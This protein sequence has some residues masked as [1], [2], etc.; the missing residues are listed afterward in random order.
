V[1]I[2]SLLLELKEKVFF[3]SREIHDLFQTEPVIGNYALCYAM[4]FAK[5]PYHIKEVKK[6]SPTYKEDIS[7][8]NVKGIYITPATPVQ[9]PEME[10]ERFNAMV[11]S[12]WYTMSNNAV[13]ADLDVKLK[14]KRASTTCFPQSGRIR[15]LSRGSMFKCFLCSKEEIKIPPYIRVGKFMGKVKV[16]IEKVF[17]NLKSEEKSKYII[18]FYLNPLD[19]GKEVEIKAYDLMSIHPVPLI[20]NIESSGKFFK[21]DD[22]YLPAG[23]E[24]SFP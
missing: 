5:S 19:I 4:G 15:F 18:P 24:F 6:E 1:Y 23:M 21:L 12:Y 9:V 22:V 17:P 14:G 16:S 8:L 7:P 3:A 13:V 11:D 10:L 2:Y 20:T